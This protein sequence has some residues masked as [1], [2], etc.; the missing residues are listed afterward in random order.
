MAHHLVDSVPKHLRFSPGGGSTRN[1]LLRNISTG[2]AGL[3]RP[4][5]CFTVCNRVSFFRV[6]FLMF[7]ACSLQQA[8]KLL[9][10]AHQIRKLWRQAD[11]M[12]LVTLPLALRRS[13]FA[14]RASGAT[15][16]CIC[17]VRAFGQEFR[18]RGWRVAFLE[19]QLDSCDLAVFDER[20]IDSTS[21]TEDLSFQNRN[22]LVSSRQRRCM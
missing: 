12:F 2:L 3:K 20:D 15:L 19:L 14:N 6:F 17:G 13:S 1:L 21:L 18:A 4:L 7:I 10:A 5:K 11:P 8:R 22:R 16:H 9:I